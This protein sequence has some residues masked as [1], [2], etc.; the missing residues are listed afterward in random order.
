[1]RNVII[2]ASFYKITIAQQWLHMM[3]KKKKKVV[4]PIS[5]YIGQMMCSL[6][7]SNSSVVKEEALK[8]SHQY[9]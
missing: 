3:K 6:Y 2:K 4:R 9:Y 8:D 7:A 5:E 1:M